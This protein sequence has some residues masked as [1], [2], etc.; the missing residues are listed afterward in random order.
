M[1]GSGLGVTT[2]AVA[3]A[4]ASSPHTPAR[5][6]KPAPAP[7]AIPP[8][9]AAHP[10][11]IV[12]VGDSLGEDLGIGLTAELAGASHVHLEALAVGDSG[13]VQTAYYNWPAALSRDLAR[14]HPQLVVVMLGGNDC[15]S[16]YDGPTLE[17]PGTASYDRV[18]AAR[19]GAFMS[20]A[21]AAR[22]RVLWVG[23]PIMQSP[24]FS[25][26]MSELNRA[27]RAEALAH[28]GALYWPSWQLFE[29][30]QGGYAEYLSLGGHEVEVRD[31]D[32]VHI[33]PPAGTDL[34][35][36]AVVREIETAYRVRL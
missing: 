13:L 14:F 10:L 33:D 26:C 19:V 17:E 31:P 27:Y 16:F 1:L 30:P 18:Y 20:E 28:P 5:A 29:S 11:T 35:G 12:E 6:V 32:G 23:L 8:P 34:I 25:S 2:A 36:A 21:L 3:A 22:A 15:Q 7:P 4:S 9:S 24:T